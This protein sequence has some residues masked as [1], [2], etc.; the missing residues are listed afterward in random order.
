M[1]FL[2]F[3]ISELKRLFPD[4]KAT[5]KEDLNDQELAAVSDLGVLKFQPHLYLG[6]FQHFCLLSKYSVSKNNSECLLIYFDDID[7]I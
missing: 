1:T 6:K 2:D 7:S 5:L 4:K 3:E